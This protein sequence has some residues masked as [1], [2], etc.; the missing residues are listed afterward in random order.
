MH[1]RAAELTVKTLQTRERQGVGSA[2]LPGHTGDMFTG[3]VEGLGRVTQHREEHGGVRMELDLGAVAEGVRT[4][5]SV[6]VAGCCLTVEAIEGTRATFFMMGE[7]L[8]LTRFAEVRAGDDL[9][10][11]RSMKLGDR[12]GGHLVS[13]HVDGLGKV[14]E[15]KRLAG[16]VRMT[17]DVPSSVLR[18]T[19]PKGSITVEGVS[20]TLAALG[21]AEV[22]LALI[23]HTLAVT[24]LGKLSAGDAVHLEADQIGKWMA[25]LVDA[26]R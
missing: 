11:E 16:E 10:L 15:V 17:L 7:T 18:F 8:R 26:T 6:A 21:A 4:G 5:D 14:R 22:E 9:N 25:R 1:R 12:L 24:T 2:K 20:L 19:I 3:I 13:G 23:P